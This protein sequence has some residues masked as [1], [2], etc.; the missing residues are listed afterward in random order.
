MWRSSETIVKLPDGTREWTSLGKNS[1]VS[2]FPTFAIASRPPKSGSNPKP[3]ALSPA[4]PSV[5]GFRPSDFS[6]R[7]QGFCHRLSDFRFNHSPAVKMWASLRMRQ[8]HPVR[9]WDY[10]ARCFSRPARCHSMPASCRSPPVR[11]CS[12]PAR[13]RSKA[14]RSH[15]KSL[16]TPSYGLGL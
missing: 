6:P 16:G 1:L 4:Y 8:D 7:H 14:V 9:S 11:C 12:L 5:F 10:L 3:K 15:S 13:S 2:I